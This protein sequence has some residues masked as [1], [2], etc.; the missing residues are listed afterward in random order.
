VGQPESA[1]DAA[2]IFQ[3]IRKIRPGMPVTADFSANRIN[4][5]LN[6]SGIVVSIRCG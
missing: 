5:N 2:P 4:F 6:D 3:P 1:V